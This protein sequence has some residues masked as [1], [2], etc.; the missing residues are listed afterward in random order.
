LDLKSLLNFL[1]VVDIN[2]YFKDVNLYLNSLS[3]FWGV[4]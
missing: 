1:R 3:Y 4:P 2:F